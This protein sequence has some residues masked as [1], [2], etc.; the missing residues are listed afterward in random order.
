VP[1]LYRDIARYPATFL[2][3]RQGHLQPAP[4]PDHPFEELE[5]AVER[6]LNAGS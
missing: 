2:I 5:A 3:D 4:G 6:L 1:N